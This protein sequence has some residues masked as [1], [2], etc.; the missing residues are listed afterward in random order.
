MNLTELITEGRANPVLLAAMA[1]VLGGLHGLEPGHSKTMIAAYIIAIRGTVS[2]AVL[3]GLS[4]ALSH[5][6]IV[7]ALA[8]TGLV[9][10]DELIGEAMEPWFMIIS[11]VIIIG[12]GVWIFRQSWRANRQRTSLPHSHGHGDLHGPGHSHD[13]DDHHHHDH[14]RGHG[15]MDAHA[16]AHARE[17]ETRLGSGR[18]S[19][20]QTILF[21]L[22]GGLI[23]CPAAITVLLLCLQLGQVSLGITLVSAFSIGL[24]LT[25]VAVGMLAAVSLR[26]VSRRSSLF[27]ALMARAPYVSS[28]LIGLIGLVMIYAGWS[29]LQH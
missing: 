6:V 19:T 17:M 2:Q 16:L 20:Y 7:W 8:V 25:L 12:L 9:Y 24:A 4:A 22:T 23:P 29:H 5:V 28:A 21:G 3:L 14:P 18:T 10:G 13:H 27:D 11:G 26:Y 1:I 15:A